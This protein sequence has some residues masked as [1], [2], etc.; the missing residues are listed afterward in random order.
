WYALSLIAHRRVVDRKLLAAWLVES[1]TAFFAAEHF[2]LDTN[3]GEG[4]AHHHF[5]V[6]PSRTVGVEVFRLHAQL[7]QVQAWLRARLDVARWRN[8]VGS[9]RVAEQG[10][11]AGAFDITGWLWRLPDVFE[12]WRVLHI[13]GIVVPGIGI[14][15]CHGNGLPML[16]TGE[17][18]SVTRAEHLP[19]DLGHGFVHFSAARPDVFQIDR[20]VLRIVAQRF[21]VHIDSCG[22]GQGEGHDQRR[23]RQPVGLD[24]WMHAPLEVAVARKHRGDDQVVVGYRLAN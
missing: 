14:A 23:R 13:A 8:V 20:L 2:V 7:L 9:D 4:A 19:V 1:V 17:Y 6:A 24:H 3:I 16:V 5:M 15:R 12:K 22:T 18:V 21:T 11:N 10:E